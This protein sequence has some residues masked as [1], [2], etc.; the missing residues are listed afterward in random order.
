M[1]D[2]KVSMSRRRFLASSGLAGV[3]TLG[4]PGVIAGIPEAN[5]KAKK[6]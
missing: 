3:A 1:T 6:E 4:L 2:N 5:A